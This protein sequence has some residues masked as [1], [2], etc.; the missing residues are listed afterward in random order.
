[1]YDRDPNDR[2]VNSMALSVLK[3]Y[4]MGYSTERFITPRRGDSSLCIKLQS[5]M[6]QFMEE[7]GE[8]IEKNL[9]CKYFH[10]WR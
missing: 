9:K 5:R 1:M 8:N 7:Y 3:R 10:P 6:I 4:S 2:K